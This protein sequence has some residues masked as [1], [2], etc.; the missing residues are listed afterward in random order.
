[1]SKLDAQLFK[2]GKQPHFCIAYVIG[3]I[4][5]YHMKLPKITFSKYNWSRSCYRPTFNKYWSGKIWNFSIYK[6]GVSI[7]FRGGFQMT[8]LLND[9][10]KKSFW[11]RIGLLGRKN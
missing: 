11:L 2:F 10:E 6:Y 3:C 7:D 4:N 8:D 1:M 5:F 9:K